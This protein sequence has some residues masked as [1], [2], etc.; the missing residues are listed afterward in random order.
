MTRCGTQ[1]MKVADMLCKARRVWATSPPTWGWVGCGGGGGDTGVNVLWDNRATAGR[2]LRGASCLH[3]HTCHPFKTRLLI[4]WFEP[5]LGLSFFLFLWIRISFAKCLY[6]L[7]CSGLCTCQLV[8]KISQE[9]CD[10]CLYIK[11]SAVNIYIQKLTCT[12]MLATAVVV[13]CC[14]PRLICICV[15]SDRQS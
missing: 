9:M 7:S 1:N 3:I 15:V 5:W 11:R 13:R 4:A 8:T 14:S 2:L 6:I 10:W 12:S